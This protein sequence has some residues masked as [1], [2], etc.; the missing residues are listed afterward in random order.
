MIAHDST[1]TLKL[2]MNFG[3]NIQ[4]KCINRNVANETLKNKNMWLVREG[5]LMEIKNLKNIKKRQIFGI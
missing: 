5:T 4:L 2:H 3:K 1:L